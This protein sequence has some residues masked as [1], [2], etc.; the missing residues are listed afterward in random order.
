MRPAA[1]SAVLP[2][3]P[4]NV[5]LTP[6]MPSGTSAAEFRASSASNRVIPFVEVAP[7]SRTKPG[8]GSSAPPRKQVVLRSAG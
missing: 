4:I 1:R 2:P 5:P 6:A 7:F 8:G 3:R